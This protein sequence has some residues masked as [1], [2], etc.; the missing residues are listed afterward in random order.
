MNHREPLPRSSAELLALIE[1]EQWRRR[2]F[3]AA[4]AVTGKEPEDGRQ[5][6]YML[7]AERKNRQWHSTPNLTEACARAMSRAATEH[8]W[9]EVETAVDEFDAFLES[10][11]Q[12]LT[13][14][15]TQ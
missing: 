15:A 10:L 2:L 1:C 9:Q 14:G 7:I 4:V 3:A 6:V 11:T 8:F 12:P 13:I 5:A